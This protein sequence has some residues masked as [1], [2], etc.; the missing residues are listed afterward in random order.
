M[1]VLIAVTAHV[2]G[3]Q[4]LIRVPDL[5]LYLPAGVAGGLIGA[6]RLRP[7]LWI[8]ATPLAL[9]CLLVAYTPLIA[10]LAKPM[11]RRDA[12]PSRVDAI[13]VLSH[14]LTPDGTMKA[15]TLDRLLAGL[16]L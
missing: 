8:A 1:G 9:I 11:I 4:Q 16:T 10:W 2:L 5:A 3:V 13:V 7:L 15:E 12:I 6:T 14:G